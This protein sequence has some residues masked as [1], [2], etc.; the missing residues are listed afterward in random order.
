MNIVTICGG[1]SCEHDISVITA[2]LARGHF[3][4]KLY[5][6]YLDKNNVPYLVGN[7]IAPRDFG[8]RKRRVVFCFGEQSFRVR[9]GIFLGKPVHIDIVVNCCHG[10]CGEDGSVAAL[11]ALLGVPLVGSDIFSSAI[12]MDKVLT[13]YVLRTLRMPVLPYTVVTKGQTDFIDVSLPT[14]VK[15][16]R[17]GSSIGV[18]LCRTREELVA[19]LD[20]AFCYDDKV[21]C[22]DAIDDFAE[23]NCSAFRTCGAVRTSRVDN[24]T[25]AHDILTF[26]DKY[27][28]GG[29]GMATSDNPPPPDSVTRRVRQLTERIYTELGFSG[30]VRVDYLFDKRRNKLYVN[31]INSVPGSLAYGLW[32][33][34]Y[35]MMEFG[36]VLAKQAIDDFAAHAELTTAFDSSVL[37]CD[38]GNGGAKTR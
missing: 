1:K 11:C 30:V 22:E 29:K 10:L 38:T 31:E 21:L 23:L 35:G 19:A 32:K 33:D 15:P 4:D 18:K 5:G 14:V 34:D 8:K 16:A 25:T 24:P 6:I 28:V 37:T 3:G 12:A 2:C 9:R 20:T 26:E 17:L 27:L 36:A 13:K 7:D